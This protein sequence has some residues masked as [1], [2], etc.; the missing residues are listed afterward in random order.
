M[1]RE[2]RM[3]LL[4]DDDSPSVRLHHARD[5]K[6]QARVMGSALRPAELV[7]VG[8]TWPST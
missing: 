7:I 6:N 8:E 3:A 1:L 2:V 4:E 5:R